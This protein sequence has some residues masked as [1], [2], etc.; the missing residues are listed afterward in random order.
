MLKTAKKN[1]L[2]NQLIEFIESVC[3]TSRCLLRKKKSTLRRSMY[4]YHEG[5]TSLFYTETQEI[6]LVGLPKLFF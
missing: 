4:H 6:Q 3:K 5:E 1:I 2:A